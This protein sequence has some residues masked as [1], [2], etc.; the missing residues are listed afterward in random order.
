MTQSNPTPSMVC[1]PSSAGNPSACDL[2]PARRSDPVQAGGYLVQ[3]QAFDDG[4]YCFS[5][6]L[7]GVW[8]A[9]TEDRALAHLRFFVLRTLASMGATAARTARRWA[10]SSVA[11]RQLHDTLAD[12]GM[13]VY[14]IAD[15]TTFW[16]LSARPLIFP[17]ATEN[18][19]GTWTTV[20]AAEPPGVLTGIWAPEA[21]PTRSF[22]F[23]A[24]RRRRAR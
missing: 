22:S 14:V 24:R 20:Q 6:S 1:A 16:E 12:G 18:R 17:T 11:E 23:T 10:E 3:F 19:S 15:G 4:E 13:Y 2:P 5:S 7:P 9:R 21:L 8:A